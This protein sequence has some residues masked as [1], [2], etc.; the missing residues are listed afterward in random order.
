M[1]TVFSSVRELQSLEKVLYLRITVGTDH[2]EGISRL[3]GKICFLET[4]NMKE[5]KKKVQ[6]LKSFSYGVTKAC[7]LL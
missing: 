7:F 5:K 6:E 4:T 1:D 2:I 3:I